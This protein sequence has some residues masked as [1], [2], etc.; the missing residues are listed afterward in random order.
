MAAEPETV[1]LAENCTQVKLRSLLETERDQVT[2]D[3]LVP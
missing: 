2:G 3:I 1:R